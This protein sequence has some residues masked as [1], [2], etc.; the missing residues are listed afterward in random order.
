MTYLH[1]KE[2]IQNIKNIYSI[3]F[4][5]LRHHKSPQN[6]CFAAIAI[7]NSFKTFVLE[8]SGNKKHVRRLF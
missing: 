3:C 5:P 7:L 6:V 2:P 8:L 1:S 4:A